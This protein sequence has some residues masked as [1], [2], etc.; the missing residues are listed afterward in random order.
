MPNQ[1]NTPQAHEKQSQWLLQTF[2]PQ[3]EHEHG[4][5]PGL[6]CGL[7]YVHDAKQ[8]QT[9]KI[10]KQGT[11]G[12][13]T[14]SNLSQLVCDLQTVTAPQNLD[15]GQLGRLHP[16]RV[17]Q[18]RAEESQ[19]LLCKLSER[20]QTGRWKIHRLA[21]SHAPCPHCEES[22]HR[23]LSMKRSHKHESGSEGLLDVY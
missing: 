13:D 16:L 23:L 12:I 10:L 18:C 20:T 7:G 2:P 14:S 5:G 1:L 4:S 17:H 8:V 11:P 6:D 3:G 9:V 22:G 21:H 19:S 15:H